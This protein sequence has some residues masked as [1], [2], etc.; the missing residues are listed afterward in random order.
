[1]SSHTTTATVSRFGASDPKWYEH[2]AKTEVT[3][4][5]GPTL[6]QMLK[7]LMRVAGQRE[8]ES[9]FRVVRAMDGIRIFLFAPGVHVEING[10]Q[11]A[12]GTQITSELDADS[13][14]GTRSLD[15]VERAFPPAWRKGWRKHP[16]VPSP[17]SERALSIMELGL[18]AIEDRTLW[19]ALFAA[20]KQHRAAQRA[21]AR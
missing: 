12:G 15:A 4:P 18:R 7:T 6:R 20:E 21:E 17:E 11:H 10:L 8:H 13:P 5:I 3:L 14:L 19:A 16:Y 1:M 9:R 2:T